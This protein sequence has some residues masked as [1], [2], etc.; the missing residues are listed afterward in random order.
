MGRAQWRNLWPK[1]D[2]VKRRSVGAAAQFDEHA[3]TDRVPDPDQGPLDTGCG[4]HCPLETKMMS[5]EPK[6]TQK[7]DE[8]I[9]MHS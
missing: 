5:Y 7:K 3:T 2:A 4:D 6:R 9:N 1:I 8:I